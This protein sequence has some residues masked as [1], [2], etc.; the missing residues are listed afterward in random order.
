M[1]TSPHFGPPRAAR[2]AVLAIVQRYRQAR[3]EH[4]AAINS[5]ASALEKRFNKQLLDG[6]R[7][8]TARVAQLLCAPYPTYS[9]NLLAGGGF[10]S[11]C[12]ASS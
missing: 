3:R 11:T 9:R 10:L 7:A 4:F 1:R 5:A 8:A 2:R 6:L 12:M